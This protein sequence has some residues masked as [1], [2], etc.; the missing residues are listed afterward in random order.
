MTKASKYGLSALKLAL[1]TR[2]VRSAVQEPELLA[3]EPLAIIGMG[4]RFPGGANSLTEFWALLERG[5]DTIEE[6]P[7]S[8]WDL[9][10][11]YDPEGKRPG[12][13]STRFGGFLSEPV[14]GFDP[15]FF[16]IAPR[17]AVAMDPQQRLLLE[18]AWEA[19]DDAGQTQEQLAGSATGAFFSIYSNDYGQQL[20]GEREAID[21]YTAV[22]ASH[23]IAAGRLSYLLDLHGP[24]LVVDTACSSS[25]VAV[26]LACQSLRARECRMALAGGVSLVL[27]P[28]RGISL[29]KWGFMAP[30]GRCKAFDAGADGWVRGEG[31]GVIAIKRFADALTD[32]DRVLAVIRGSAANQDGRSSVLTAPNGSAQQAVVRAALASGL[33]QPEE[34]TYV[35]AHGTGTSIGDPIELDAL[36]EVL[37]RPANG[38]TCW[39]GAVKSNLGHLEAAAGIA[40]LIKTVLALRAKTVPGTLHFKQLNPLVSLDGTR[41]RVATK[42][43]PWQVSG[44]RL[45]GVSAFGFS[46]TNAHVVLEEAPPVAA[47]PEPADGRIYVLPLSARSPAALSA[48][49][50]AYAGALRADAAPALR[51][52]DVCFTAALRRTHHD[53]RLVV[54]GATRDELLDALSV[55]AAGGPRWDIARNRRRMGRRPQP[56]FVF[57]GQGPQWWGMARDLLETEPVFRSRIDAIGVELARW[58][59]WS[60]LEE[61]R[62]DEHASHLDQTAYAQPVIFAVQV[63]LTALLASWGITPAAVVGHSVGEIAAAHV[64]GVLDLPTAVRVAFQRGRLMQQGT[65]KGRMAALG[66]SAEAARRLIAERTP[67][68]ALA[69]VNGPQSVTVAGDPES[70]ER[71]LAAL[72]ETGTFARRLPVDYA[73]HSQQMEP[74]AQALQSELAGLA[75]GPAHLPLWSTVSGLRAE[76]TDFD[77]AYW[78]RNVR[79]TVNFWPAIEA[80]LPDG[81]DVFLEIAAQPVLGPSLRQALAP[82]LAD[83]VVLPTLQRGRPAQLALRVAAA[84]LHAAGCALSWPALVPAGGRVVSLPNYP[85]QRQRYWAEVGEFRTNKAASTADR[86]QAAPFPGRRLQSPGLSGSVF[87]VNLSEAFPAWVAEHRIHDLVLYPATAFL[88]WACTALASLRGVA[89]EAVVLLDVEILE[90]LPLSQAPRHAQILI[91][92]AHGFRIVSRAE[93]GSQWSTHVT[94]RAEDVSPAREPT[95]PHV[96]SAGTQ[97][98]TGAEFYAEL[99]AHGFRFGP[100]FQTLEQIERSDSV[101]T[102]SVRLQPGTWSADEAA[103]LLLDGC[104][105]V[106]WSALPERI[107]ANAAGDAF[108]PT[109]LG[110]VSLRGPLS[111]RL[112]SHVRVAAAPAD[113]QSFTVQLLVTD[114]AGRPL[115]ELSD[116]KV[117]RASRSALR[118]SR[119]AVQ[120]WLYQLEW[121]PLPNAPV[122][123][124]PPAFV[125][126]WLILGDRAGTGGQLAAALE[127]LG[128]QAVLIAA[129]ASIDTTP[130]L[131]APGSR[132]VDCRPLDATL[133]DHASSADLLAVQEALL[134][135]TLGLLQ[136]LLGV[137]GRVVGLSLI[138]AGAQPLAGSG[139]EQGLAQAPLLGLMRALRL[140]HPELALKSID[141]DGAW[142]DRRAQADSV[143]Q[144]LIHAAWSEDELAFRAGAWRRPR[145]V[146]RPA[147]AQS[148]DSVALLEIPERGALERLRLRSLTRTSPGPGQVALDVEA[149]GLNFRDV[150]NALGTYPGDAGPL[151]QECAGT[152]AAV[153]SD[154]VGLAVG[155]RVL[156][157]TSP[158]LGTYALAPAALVVK[159]PAGLSS[160]AAATLPIAFMTARH[161]LQALAGLARGER[162]LIHAA[163]G[164]VG[165]AAV[166]IALGLGAEVFATAGSEEKHAVLHALGVRYVLSSRSLD[167]AEQIRKLTDGKGVDV[168]LNS[169]SGDFIPRSLELLAERGR[170]VEIGKLGVWSA[171]QVAAA[172]PDVIY[173]L[174]YLGELVQRD[175]EAARAL[176]QGIVTDVAAG[177]LMPLPFQEFA[178][179]QASEAFRFM[180]QARHI[181]KLVLCCAPVRVASAI[182]S[183][184]TYL[185]TGGLGAL[186]LATAVGLARHG[187][188]HLALVGRR[189][190]SAAVNQQL[191]ALRAAGVNVTVL[192]GDVAREA[193]VQTWLELVASTMPPLIGVFHAAGVVD[194]GVLTHQSWPRFRSVLEPKALGAWNL[195]RATRHLPLA[196]FVLFSSVAGVIGSP[197]Q[198]NYAAANVFLDALAQFRNSSGLPAL[199]IQWGAWAGAGMA[200]S[201]SHED[202]R[203]WSAR[204]AEE[205]TPEAGVELLLCLLRTS[206]TTVMVS[207]MSWP[208]PAGG[209]VPPLLERLLSLAGPPEQAEAQPAL[210]QRVRAAPIRRRLALL[211]QFVT[212]QALAAL[213]LPANY[214]L[215]PE[216]GLRDVGL[217]SLMAVELKNRL[218]SALHKPLPTTL[219]FDY[220]T[221]SALAHYLGEQLGLPLHAPAA[222]APNADSIQDLTGLSDE[223]AE[224]LLRQELALLGSAEAGGI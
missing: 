178:I 190:P 49:A 163:A 152:V 96:A 112:Q 61:L 102:A 16:G 62:A 105:Q 34:I 93:Q 184:G 216:Q 24:S 218:Q 127:R 130:H 20:Y 104:L 52:V 10:R 53:L 189:A 26:H 188:R 22:G 134:G 131:A 21:A 108:V 28:D 4:C 205:I 41:L 5:G 107:R 69:A 64:A 115:A 136:T 23:S 40:G 19:L 158:C 198:A 213:G 183:D 15:T 211:V 173:H 215:D 7:S 74:F 50:T 54:S 3:A 27:T 118:G 193:D 68:L 116:L 25:L 8:R 14:D 221:A 197:G 196:C 128:Q 147:L 63:A 80:L 88:R 214:V 191:S 13:M 58:A 95:G 181:G 143:A 208:T 150:L 75:P 47:L 56:V 180:A 167:F 1:A 222:A 18:V 139:L 142:K 66:L 111:G 87:E 140:E 2:E 192:A 202:R 156:A 145:L 224:E 73:F 182:R 82:R 223:E 123:A 187:A 42:S 35:E 155:D 44:R 39:I 166:Q 157:A 161:A 43:E 92:D 91:D 176:L 30:D 33:V 60:L 78:A 83:P 165:L 86:A 160:A 171:E 67:S 220:P 98:I 174:L 212:E 185:I 204:G 89:P 122:A 153:G 29:S 103:L 168:V 144:A 12:T 209:R 38:P 120:E 170:F 17:E 79:D 77:A 45:A 148:P 199:S 201:L 175:P 70:I 207:P 114:E 186:G 200:A 117:S 81:H 55:A 37:G 169:L 48:L 126:P 132:V 57:S 210:E 177:R 32:G 6:V 159:L 124:E 99:G 119:R 101:A 206:V 72:A 141:L 46:G 135:G 97:H 85:W 138:T 59:S 125:G 179:E 36:A 219:A 195:H 31:C 94:G 100:A 84:N 106:I 151:G 9:G 146:R 90:P 194:D 154:V 110:R 149:A 76:A 113:A 11:Y 71:L 51:A 162:V 203:R 217:D 129:G 65:G 137:P 164:G 133:T 172:R 121:E 109:A